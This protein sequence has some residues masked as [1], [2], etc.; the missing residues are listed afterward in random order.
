MNSREQITTVGDG[1]LVLAPAKINLSLLIAGKRPDGFHEIETI[2]AKIDWYDE[3]LIQPGRQTGIELTCRGPHWAPAG[4]DNLVYK[5]AKSLLESCGLTPNVRINLTKNIPAGTGLGSASSDAAATLIG[6]N[7]YFKLGLDQKSLFESAAKLGSDVAF[8]LGGPLAFCTGKGEKVKKINE[9]FN[10]TALLILPDI[11]I[12]TKKVY[13]N[14]QHNRQLYKKLNIRL[15]NHIIKNRIDLAVKMCTNMLAESC[16]ELENSLAELKDA[17][18]SL[19]IGPCC[20]SGSGSAMF[21]IIESGDEGEAREGMS[22][23]A[24]KI[25][26]KSIIVR[27]NRW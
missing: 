14:Y 20:L 26:C 16:F 15:K 25:G 19:G 10:F 5:A 22:E 3:I 18:E 12:S 8:F 2:M 23:L 4:E 9:I 11:S 17:I 7:H 1:L 6:I 13:A 27:N 24:E 21:C